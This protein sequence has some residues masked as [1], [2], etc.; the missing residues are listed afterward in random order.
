MIIASW[1]SAVVLEYYQVVEGQRPDLVIFNRSRWRTAKYYEF[2]RQGMARNTILSQ[3]DSEEV[4]LIDQ[5]MKERTMYAVEYDPVLAEK[6]EYL[7]E[8]LAFR[9]AAQ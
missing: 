9:L 6:F 2:W 7:P 3:I 5:Y 1:S 8:G 4:G